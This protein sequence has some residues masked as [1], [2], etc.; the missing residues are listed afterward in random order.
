MSLTKSNASVS[1]EEAVSHKV[2]WHSWLHCALN[3]RCII[4]KQLAVII[5]TY[6]AKDLR[7]FNFVNFANFQPFVKRKL[8]T[9]DTHFHALT[10]RASMDNILGLSCWVHEEL[11]P[12]RYL[13]SR[14]WCAD[15]CKL[16]Q[17]TTGWQLACHAHSILCMQQ[18]RKI[19]SMK[20]SKI[21]I[22]E[23]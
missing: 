4:V 18:I 23:I 12:R 22:R 14:H 16:K 8:F 13:Q 7:V 9:C 11:S 10:A 3:F 17:T 19:I 6:S 21:A 1:Q 15:S 20:S 2:E 5:Y